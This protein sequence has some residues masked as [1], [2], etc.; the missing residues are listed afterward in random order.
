MQLF[1]ADTNPAFH[2][3]STAPSPG[4]SDAAASVSGLVD[5]AEFWRD[6]VSDHRVRKVKMSNFDP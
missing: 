6:K 3:V 5:G 4:L 1:K 2:R